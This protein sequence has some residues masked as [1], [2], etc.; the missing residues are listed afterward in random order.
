MVRVAAFALAFLALASCGVL[1]NRENANDPLSPYYS[2]PVSSD[3][4][5]TADTNV[6][7]R[8]STPSDTNGL[9]F[10]NTLDN[11][12]AVAAGGYGAGL[13][14]S[15]SPSYATGVFGGG[16]RLGYG[17][18]VQ[19]EGSLYPNLKGCL[20][21]WLIPDSSFGTSGQNMLVNGRTASGTA[22]IPTFGYSIP[23]Q[24]ILYWTDDG[25]DDIRATRSFTAGRK[26]HIALVWD[27]AGIGGGIDSQRIYVDG[28]AV[29]ASQLMTV[30]NTPAGTT[31]RFGNSWD[32]NG[33]YHI[34]VAA[35]RQSNLHLFE[36]PSARGY[37]V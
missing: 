26:Y 5:S 36:I 9:I 14:K 2:E 23:S 19:F 22:G 32:D 12:T 27:Y 17:S 13:G 35:S 3:T 7:T 28:V 6:Y 37:F 30:P 25:N 24:G 29:T 21:F 31:I 15:G 10:W 20:E 4:G 18:W 34:G 1:R 16:I 33:R 8:S 11:D